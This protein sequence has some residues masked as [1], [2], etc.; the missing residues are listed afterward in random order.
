MLVLQLA[1]NFI[2]FMLSVQELISESDG[3]DLKRCPS[4]Q[5]PPLAS[6]ASNSPLCP[7]PDDD[8]VQNG[9]TV[10]PLKSFALTNVSTGHA[11][12]PQ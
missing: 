3:F 11:A 6:S 7:K 5:F 8:D 10:F 9:I 2:Y 12:I 4:N 1:L